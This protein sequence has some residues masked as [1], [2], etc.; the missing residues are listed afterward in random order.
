MTHLIRAVAV[1]DEP[2]ALQKI[3]R[4]LSLDHAFDLVALCENG[5]DAIEI[6]Q[7]LRPDVLFLDVQMPQISGFDVLNALK[8][9]QAESPFLS[10]LITA[11]DEYAVQ[12]F[13][14]NAVDYLLKPFDAERFA[15]MLKKLKSRF[16]LKKIEPISDATLNRLLLAQGVYLEKFVVKKVGKTLIVRVE[17]VEW[18]KADGNYIELHCLDGSTHLVRETIQHLESCLNPNRFVR[19][20]RSAIVAVHHIKSLCPTANNDYLLTLNSGACL[21]LSRTYREKAFRALGKSA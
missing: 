8:S 20:H 17:D 5:I 18:L 9:H 13:N 19:I 10:V 3:Q 6:C 7:S 12:A 2:L 1:D 21:S 14:E 4:L 16:Y 15:V 11:H